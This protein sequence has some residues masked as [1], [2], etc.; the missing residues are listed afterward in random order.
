[1]HPDAYD[2]KRNAL[3]AEPE[4]IS[5]ATLMRRVLVRASELG[6]RLF[7]NQTG[8]Y[9]LARPECKECQSRGRVIASGLCVGSSDLI[10]WRSVRITPEMVG[11]Q[12]A[13]FVGA[14]I[15]GPDGRLTVEQMQFLS[16]VNDAGGI[17]MA[18]RDVADLDVWKP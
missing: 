9:R 18:V 12:V 6:G 13:V 2:R 7:R 8:R 4:M 3:L 17:A 16:A 10:G 15:K 11:N 14:E 1:M 5:E